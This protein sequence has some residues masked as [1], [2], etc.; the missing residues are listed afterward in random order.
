LEGIFLENPYFKEDAH[1]D[2]L[3]DKGI[4]EDAILSE[5]TFVG[6]F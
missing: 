5:G 4:F 2:A 6:V 3:Q 1:E